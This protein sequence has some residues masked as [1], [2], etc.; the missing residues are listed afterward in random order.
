MGIEQLMIEGKK[1]GLTN[2]VPLQTENLSV[3]DEVRQ[4]C[5][6]N[7]CGLY[8]ANWSCPPGC[9]SLEECRDTIKKFRTGLLV[10]TVGEIEDSFDFENMVLIEKK[11][12]E[13]FIKFYDYLKTFYPK[14]LALGAGGCT[15]CKTCTYPSA[16]CLFPDKMISS[17]EAYGLLVSQVCKSSDLPYYYGSDRLAYTSCYLLE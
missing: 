16:P 13:N 7:T 5:A 12:K 6:S 15:R 11:H 8:D 4:M 10:Q 1:M 17:M 3:M 14:A 9:G 2:I